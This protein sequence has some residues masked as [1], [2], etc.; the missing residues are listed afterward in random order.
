MACNAIDA[1]IPFYN[2]AFLL[3]LGAIKAGFKL[4]LIWELVEY[5]NAIDTK[6]LPALCG[7]WYRL[8]TNKH[9][10]YN[11]KLSNVS[12]MILINLGSTS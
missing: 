11:L 12:K 2:S 8:H 7:K 4:L 9:N 6:Y 5:F 10:L 3:K 1:N